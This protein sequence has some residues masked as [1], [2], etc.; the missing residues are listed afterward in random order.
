MNARFPRLKSGASTQMGKIK[1]RT[2]KDQGCGTRRQPPKELGLRHKLFNLQER[3]ADALK[4]AP[5]RH[6]GCAALRHKRARPLK[7]AATAT[8]VEACTIWSHGATVKKSGGKPPHS[9]RHAAEDHCAPPLGF[10]LCRRSS[11]CFAS[12]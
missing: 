4:R 11:S 5:T 7:R 3:T 12:V 8:S 6:A 2:L 10:E 9:I 1:P